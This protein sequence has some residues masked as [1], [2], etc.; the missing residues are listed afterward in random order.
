MEDNNE[1]KWFFLTVK[2]RCE[3]KVIKDIKKMDAFEIEDAISP[4]IEKDDKKLIYFA[5][6]YVFIKCTKS[7][8]IFK[9]IKK[10]PNVLKILTDSRKIPVAFSDK[11]IQEIILHSKKNFENIQKF[12]IG[13]KVFI[14]HGTFK[15]NYGIIEDIDLKKLK[16]I[17]SISVLGKQ[18]PIELNV[19][20]IEEAI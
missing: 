20:E 2:T 12:D 5:P 15:D 16:I 6:G 11:K 9:K 14:K 7:Y 10:I 13:N 8:E 19:K 17:V 4:K 3:E 1:K 18:I